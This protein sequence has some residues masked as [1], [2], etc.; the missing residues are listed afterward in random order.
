MRKWQSA[1]VIAAVTLVVVFALYPPLALRGQPQLTAAQA[2]ALQPTPP[3]L[4][5]RTGTFWSVSRPDYPPFPFDPYPDLPVYLL[6]DGSYLVDDSSVQFP[7]PGPVDAA[8]AARSFLTQASLASQQ[9]L[10]NDD[11]FPG[12]PGDTN[13]PPQNT[14]PQLLDPGSVP[15]NGTFWFLVR[16]NYPALPY[17][18][19]TNC[20]V[21][22]LSD[23]SYLVDDSS[24]VWPEPSGGGGSQGP[25]QPSYSTNDLWLEITGVTNSMVNLI[26]HGT[27]GSTAYT[28]LSRGC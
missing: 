4:V 9:R 12:M 19:C 2:A 15:T 22:L 8:A 10:A 16:S 21:Y 5:P 26:L 17:D 20:D 18:P 25:Y 14:P 27:V 3:S 6:P 24:Y 11:S 23:G 7:P 1:P 13:A 28:I